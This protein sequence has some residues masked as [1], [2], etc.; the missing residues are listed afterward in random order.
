MSYPVLAGAEPFSFD[1]GDV[2]V[3][4]LHG[5]T[6][7][8]QGLRPWGEALREAGFTVRCPRLPGHG[9]D[10]RD[11]AARRAPEMVAAS[12]RALD[13]LAER[14]GKVVVGALSFGGALALHLVATR[15]D[16]VRGLVTV[17]PWLYSKDRRLLLLPVLKLLVA[18]APGVGSDLADS[19]ARELAYEH[20]PLRTLASL[21]SFQRGVR[22]ALPRVTQPLL[23]FVSRHDHVVDPGNTELVAARAGSDDLR[24][25]WLEHSY[26]VATLDLE[27]HAIFD[28]SIEFFR[29]VTGAGRAQPKT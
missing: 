22:A 25:V 24:V 7:S 5:F 6:G 16:K 26:H 1:G 9:T 15:P 10:W 8:P 12:E 27:R 20:V 23:C 17:N 13:E 28:G 4:L 18:S 14:C 3:L 2:G 11:L 21:R 29:R 19:E